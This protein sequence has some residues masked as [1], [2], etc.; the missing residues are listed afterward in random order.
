MSQPSAVRSVSE[1]LAQYEI[2][3]RQALA[4]ADRSGP[5]G[6]ELAF[7]ERWGLAAWVKGGLPRPVSS[8]APE[9]RQTPALREDGSAPRDLILVLAGL[10][11]GDRQE[12]QDVQFDQHE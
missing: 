3:R 5:G 9:D 6:A 4:S 11:L 12:G 8:V 2:L 1:C 7:I 10:V